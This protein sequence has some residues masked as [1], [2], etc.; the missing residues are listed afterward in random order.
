VAAAGLAV[1]FVF[2]EAGVVVAVAVAGV[3]LGDAF[4]FAFLLFR[5]VAFVTSG[6]ALRAG[7]VVD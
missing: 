1:A 4:A 7:V 6:V 2:G 5:R 3:M